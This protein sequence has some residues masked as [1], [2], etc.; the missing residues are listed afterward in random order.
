MV[1]WVADASL[2][3]DLRERGEENAPCAGG[4]ATKKCK[5]W[6]PLPAW[7]FPGLPGTPAWDPLVTRRGYC[8]SQ[9][10]CGVLGNE[11]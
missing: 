7:L 10:V 3:T 2:A 9:P 8:D 6:G 11:Y 1:L 5:K 4:I